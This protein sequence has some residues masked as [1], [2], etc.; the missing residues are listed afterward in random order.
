[1]VPIGDINPRPFQQ[2]RVWHRC[3]I[4]RTLVST[5][6]FASNAARDAKPGKAEVVG[7]IGR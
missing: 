5:V 3:L 1:M 4:R 6:G 7:D 2:K